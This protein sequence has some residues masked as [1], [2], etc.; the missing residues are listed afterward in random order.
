MHLK[1]LITGVEAF[2]ASH[3]V[4]YIL[5]NAPEVEIYGTSRRLADRS[6]IAHVL[7]RIKIQDMELMD[8]HSVFNVVDSVKPDKV[9]HL[10]AQSF[11]PASWTSPAATIET[12]TIGTV[13]LLEAVRKC[14]PSAYVHVQG[15]SEEYG[16][17]L[18]GETPITEENPLRPLSPYGVSKVGADLAGYQYAHSHHMNITR[19]RSF[20]MTGARRGEVFATSNFAKQIAEAELNI[21]EPKLLHGNLEAIRDFTDVRDSVRAYW[22]LSEKE[23]HGDVYN[24]CSGKGWTMK[25]VIDILIECSGGGVIALIADPERMRPSDVPILIGCPYKVNEFTGWSVRYDF[26]ETMAYLYDYWL[27]KLD[28][29]YGKK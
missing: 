20:N 21:R 16:M 22:M 15:S 7:D 25:E 9:F 2:V 11:V 12:N 24:V 13:H 10:A 6:N 28:L 23:A 17:V 29:T 27:K 1:V 5:E 14:C 8:F 26:K 18:M 4:D 19:V 3:L